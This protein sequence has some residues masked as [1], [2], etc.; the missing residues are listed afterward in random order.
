VK[1]LQGAIH[2]CRIS[3]ASVLLVPAGSVMRTFARAANGAVVADKQ[4]LSTPATRQTFVPL[5]DLQTFYGFGHHS[6]FSSEAWFRSLVTSRV[7]ALSDY[8]I[9][10]Q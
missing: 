1:L 8:R 4:E 3:V 5:V 9:D 2:T 7:R 6:R 10:L